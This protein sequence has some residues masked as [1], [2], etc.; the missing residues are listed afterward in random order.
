L[1]LCFLLVLGDFDSA[2]PALPLPPMI[3]LFFF[4]KDE[5]RSFFFLRETP[6]EAPGE[7]LL[8]FFG[9]F[10]FSL[11][12]SWASLYR[13]TYASHWPSC[14][15]KV[16]SRK[17]PQRFTTSVSSVY[18]KKNETKKRKSK[19]EE[20]FYKHKNRKREQKEKGFLI[21]YNEFQN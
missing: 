17:R 16:F 8:L 20:Q 2:P 6:G 10:F 21:R 7:L 13:S 4:S 5:E 11:I 14:S 9:I 12:L 18:P 3:S 1:F 19:R 15:A